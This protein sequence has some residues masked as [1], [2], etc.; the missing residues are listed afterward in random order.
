MAPKKTLENRPDLLAKIEIGDE[1]RE[2]LAE[3]E[4]HQKL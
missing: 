4:R 3:I 1:D 2:I